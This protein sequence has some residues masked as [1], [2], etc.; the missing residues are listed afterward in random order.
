MAEPILFP[1]V[2]EWSGENPGISLKEHADGPFVTLASFF[3][4][5]LSPFGRG[6]ALVLLQSPQD[7]APPAAQANLCLTDNER[8]ARFLVDGFVTNF[9]AFKGTPGLAGLAYRKLDEVAASGD[10]GSV[11]SET[12]APGN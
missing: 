4:V 8:L 3:R 11:Y 2:V 7:A 10:P 6:H 1:G 5:V 9:G 12:Y